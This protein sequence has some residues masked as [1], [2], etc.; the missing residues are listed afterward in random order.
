MPG[1][2]LLEQQKGRSETFPCFSFKPRVENAKSV[3]LMVLGGGRKGVWKPQNRTEKRQKNRKPHRIFTRI[4]KPRVQVGHNMKA[5]VSKT[6]D[7][8]W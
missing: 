3:H 2:I 8:F 4:P 7:I 6:C 1:Y 5:D